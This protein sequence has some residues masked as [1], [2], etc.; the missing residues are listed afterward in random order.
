M[1]K[2][3]IFD[4]DGTIGNST[5]FLRSVYNV[6]AEKLGK[7]KLR[8]DREYGHAHGEGNYPQLQYYMGIRTPAEIQRA[9]AIYRQYLPLYAERVKVYPNIRSVLKELAKNF[10]LAVASGN[11]RR[12]VQQILRREKVLQQFEFV[13][14][15]Q[16]RIKPDPYPLLILL[17]K[18][19]LNPQEAVYITDMVCD[20]HLAKSIG[21]KVLA[22]G[23]GFQASSFLKPHKP[24]AYAATPKALIKAVTKL[25]RA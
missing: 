10:R 5:S 14:D 1:L 18:M 24:H 25:H 12:A 16:R 11:H 22:V 8:S 2:A 3:L 17:R 13:M 4:F 20:I 19:I 21:M 15:W 23:Y 6:M 9:E 7:K